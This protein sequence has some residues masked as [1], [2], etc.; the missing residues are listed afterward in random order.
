MRFCHLKL[1]KYSRLVGLKNRLVLQKLE[2]VS[3]HLAV[4]F[5]WCE[6]FQYCWPVRIEVKKIG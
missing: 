5:V 2:V 4:Q 3:Q 1:E 6:D